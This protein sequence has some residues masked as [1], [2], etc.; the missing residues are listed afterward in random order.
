MYQMNWDMLEKVIEKWMPKASFADTQISKLRDRI[1][2]L[3]DDVE[4]ILM[5][6]IRDKSNAERYDRMIEKR[7]AEIAATKKQ[8]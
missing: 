3:E 8:I 5:E 2:G 7:E 6:R 4:V 1:S